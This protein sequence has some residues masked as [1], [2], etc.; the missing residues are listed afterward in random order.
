MGGGGKKTKTPK[1][2]NYEALAQQEGKNN[3][4]LAQYL[5]EANRASQITPMGSSTWAQAPATQ[6]QWQTQWDAINA[7]HQAAKQSKDKALEK[8]TFDQLKALET[9]PQKWMQDNST[10]TQTTALSPQEQ[11]IYNQGVNNR[12]QAASQAQKI[13]QATADR[14]PFEPQ[15]NDYSYISGPAT[16]FV[17]PQAYT[18][19]GNGTLLEG[20]EYQNTGTR[21]DNIG[22]D[23]VGQYAKDAADAIYKN[24]TQYLDENNRQVTD[25]ER[26]RLA[27]MGLQEGS[28]AYTRALDQL[29]RN[30]AGAYQTAANN[31]VLGGYQV[32]SQNLQNLLGVQQGNQANYGQAMQDAINQL[33]G[34]N[35]AAQIAGANYNLRQQNASNLANNQLALAQNYA[36]QRAQE[37]QEQL[38][39]SENN[40]AIRAQQFQEQLKLRN[41]PLD[42]LSAL[43]S[44][45]PVAYPN[46]NGYSAATNPGTPDLVNAANLG[47]QAKLGATNANRS[48]KGSTLN[49]GAQFG[50]NILGGLDWGSIFS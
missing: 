42:E 17:D 5:T 11:P 33:T 21:V 9:N 19:Q 50:G 14:G 26:A 37:V 4:E 30:Q 45:S 35:Q 25:A 15:L 34:Q 12:Y 3:L 29:Q 46:F 28:Q 2:P 1:M 20:G 48:K 8:T 39:N 23:Q 49:A 38:A 10:W 16:N 43:L 27:G 7:Q 40:R 13:F 47:Y 18:G 36:R 44:G 31:A 24:Q 41:Q 32:G 22:A 6:Q